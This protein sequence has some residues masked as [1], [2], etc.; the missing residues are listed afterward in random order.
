MTLYRRV[1]GI[2][3]G[4]SGLVAHRASRWSTVDSY[5][6]SVGMMAS[7][8]NETF[9]RGVTTGV[10]LARPWSVLV[11]HQ[12]GP[13]WTSFVMLGIK[14]HLGNLWCFGSIVPVNWKV[15]EPVYTSIT[16]VCTRY[17]INWFDCIS[18]IPAQFVNAIK[19]H[20]DSADDAATH[21]TDDRLTQNLEEQ[22]VGGGVE[23]GKR[24]R[25]EGELVRRNDKEEEL[26]V[27]SKD[28]TKG[29][30]KEKMGAGRRERERGTREGDTE[31]NL[32]NGVLA[33]TAIGLPISNGSLDKDLTSYSLAATVQ[34]GRKTR[35][36]TQ[37]Y[38]RRRHED[39][40]YSKTGLERLTRDPSYYI[41]PNLTP[42]ATMV[43]PYSVQAM[44]VRT[45]CC[46]FFCTVSH[47]AELW[48]HPAPSKRSRPARPA[49]PSSV[50]LATTRK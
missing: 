30:R 35:R 15:V 40:F 41:Q 46:P 11:L 25:M 27:D 18:S 16:G 44:T 24:K 19:T 31:L 1:K 6:D 4:L 7:C 34:N 43:T 17:A 47:N 36:R 14:C 3:L 23:R 22:G 50:E 8:D 42:L 10:T 37:L 33:L 20:K 29:T 5:V 12:F 21:L 49:A 9:W 32:A 2:H 26:R 48:Q 38:T 28:G 39:P 45:T 13:V